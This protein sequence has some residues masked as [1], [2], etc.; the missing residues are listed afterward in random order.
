MRN[1]AVEI[2]TELHSQSQYGLTVGGWFPGSVQDACA[3]ERRRP[4]AE[5]GGPTRSRSGRD[6]RGGPGW[7]H[8]ALGTCVVFQAFL[9]L[10]ER[11]KP[12]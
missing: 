2:P 3:G 9:S 5:G 11:A 4:T 10:G 7:P 8:G 1:N 6:L 12:F